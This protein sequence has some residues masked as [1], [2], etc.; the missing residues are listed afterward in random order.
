MSAEPSVRKGRRVVI[1]CRVMEP[2]LNHVIAEEGGKDG[3]LDIVYLDQLLHRTPGKLLDLVQEKIDQIA[4]TASRIV[5][6][7]GL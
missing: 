4:Q 7:Y 6:G 5:L 3:G 1:A 2:E